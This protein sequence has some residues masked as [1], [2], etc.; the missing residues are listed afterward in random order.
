MATSGSV[1]KLNTNYRP[2]IDGLRAIAVTAVIFYHLGIGV[3]TGGYVGVDIFFVISGYLIS[4]ILLAEL[5]K[6]NFTFVKFYERRIRRIFPALIVVLVSSCLAACALLPPAK[7]RDFGQSLVATISFASNIYFRLKSGYFNA[8]A[9]LTPLL[10]MWS[11]SVEEQFYIAFPILLIGLRR[12]AERWLNIALIG[13]LALSLAYSCAPLHHDQVGNFFYPH[14]RAWELALGGLVAANRDKYCPAIATHGGWALSI[15]LIGAALIVA[16]I[17]LYTAQTVF[18]GIAAIPP[19]LGTA[20]VI[21]AANRGSVVGRILATPPL[22][23]IGLISYSAYL[24]HQPLFAFVRIAM[25]GATPPVL[26]IALVGAT[27]GLAYLSWRFV[28]RPFRDRNRI[29]RRQ[30]F[31]LGAAASISLFALGLAM[32]LTRGFPQRYSAQA[33][34]LGATTTPS[35]LTAACHTDGIS[36]RHPINACHYFGKNV[37]W[38]VLGDSHGLQPAYALAEDLAKSGHGLVHLTFSACEPALLFESNNPGCSL[39]IREAVNYLTVHREIKNVFLAFRYSRALSGDQLR[40]YP[41]IP[42][43]HPNFLLHDTAPEARD[44][45]ARSLKLLVRQLSASGKTVYLMLP[46]PEL[47]THVDHYIYRQIGGNIAGDQPTGTSM[48]YYNARNRYILNVISSLAAVPHVILIDPRLAVCSPLQ[49]YSISN[50]EALYV[51]D[52]HLSV[53]GARR[54]IAVER[55]HGVLP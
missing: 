3:F 49:C 11:L 33:R 50:G 41:N 30:I 18:P 15:E 31:M 28:E 6:N 16:P 7:L 29:S 32:D 13:V 37:D 25:V 4:G 39:W 26:Q 22:V 54:L 36:Y 52:N 14:T 43:E 2:E 42:D 23:G 8:D 51:D 45:Y 34:A 44:A 53:A 12:F 46:T 5:T 48:A 9:E 19:V 1:S 20:M 38:A 35:P 21:F 40:L 24:W 55:E 10:H 17:F 27:F 47:P